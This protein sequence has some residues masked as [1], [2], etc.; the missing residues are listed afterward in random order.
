MRWFLISSGFLLAASASAQEVD[1]EKHE[2]A[3]FSPREIMTRGESRYV[4]EH[5]AVAK[6]RAV[7]VLSHCDRGS[8]VLDKF[9]VPVSSAEFSAF[10]GKI[11]S[12]GL[13]SFDKAAQVN[14]S[15]TRSGYSNE[16]TS[17]GCIAEFP[18]LGSERNPVRLY[19]QYD[20][21]IRL[22]MEMA[23]QSQ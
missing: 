3:L 16:Q 23:E 2:Q 9:K 22:K 11:V 18:E 19:V 10:K 4:L 1:C 5:F 17:C 6:D 14:S 21:A 20:E 15:I 8:F 13:G 7:A 12:A